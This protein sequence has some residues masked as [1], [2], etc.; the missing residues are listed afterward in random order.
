MALAS[1]VRAEVQTQMFV[2]G[3]IACYCVLV[4]GNVNDT[5]VRR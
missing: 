5:I 1:S 3:V 2:G 4:P